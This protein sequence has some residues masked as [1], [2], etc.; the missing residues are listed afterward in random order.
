MVR[1]ANRRYPGNKR[2][3]PLVFLDA[4]EAELRLA[5]LAGPAPEPRQANATDEDRRALTGL[6]PALLLT[7][8]AAADEFF[9]DRLKSESPDAVASRYQR[10]GSYG[11]AVIRFIAERVITATAKRLLDVAPRDPES[12]LDQTV[13][14]NLTALPIR[15][16]GSRVRPRRSEWRDAAADTLLAVGAG[17]CITAGCSADAVTRSYCEKH[18]EAQRAPVSLMQTNPQ[19]SAQSHDAAIASVAELLAEVGEILGVPR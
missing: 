8:R 12:W 18:E 5:G 7:Q 14:L 3:R 10:G 11:H 17:R 6:S 9:L 16:R 13:R 19:L 1:D 15:G 2:K 4:P